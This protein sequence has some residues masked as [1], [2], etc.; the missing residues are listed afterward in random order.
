MFYKNTWKQKDIIKHINM[1]AYGRRMKMAVRN[2]E[3]GTKWDTWIKWMDGERMREREMTDKW[4]N[5]LAKRE[6]WANQY[7]GVMN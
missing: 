6:A 3:M 5:Q 1:T 4:A 7:Y 2:W